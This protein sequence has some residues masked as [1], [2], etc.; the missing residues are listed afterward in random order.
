MDTPLTEKDLLKLS[1]PQLKAM[2]KERKITAYSKLN[3]PGIIQKLLGYASSHSGAPNVTKNASGPSNNASNTLCDAPASSPSPPA[4]TSSS[5]GQLVGEPTP[6]S[7]E[8]VAPL[9]ST[10][11]PPPCSIS[12]SI[13]AP[14][15]KRAAEDAGASTPQP[16]KKKKPNPSLIS[17]PATSSHLLPASASASASAST[18]PPTSVPLKSVSNVNITTS[19]VQEK[20]KNQITLDPRRDLTEN[21]ALSAKL[22]KQFPHSNLRPAAVLERA[23]DEKEKDITAKSTAKRFTPLVAKKSSSLAAISKIVAHGNTARV[24]AATTP[25]LPDAHLDFN[26]HPETTSAA[27][28]DLRTISL[29]PSIPQRKLVERYAL[30]LRDVA[31]E[32]IL[33]CNLA[34]KL[35]RYASEFMCR[36][37]NT[38]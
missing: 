2:C 33:S 35:I 4:Q 26:I 14:T 36:L 19:N 20:P 31:Y 16:I 30:A 8:S 23:P 12:P 10:S 24:R 18:L 34:S 22:H 28:G 17:T 9:P 7:P 27:V 29:P 11:L 37:N 15:P 6:V 38:A 25:V 5:N 21:L 3:K 13:N 32:D 1:I